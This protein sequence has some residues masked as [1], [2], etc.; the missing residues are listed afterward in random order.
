MYHIFY[1]KNE[2]KYDIAKKEYGIDIIRK[3]S[4]KNGNVYARNQTLAQYQTNKH[5]STDQHF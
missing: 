2:I 1:L 4:L 5:V 3:K